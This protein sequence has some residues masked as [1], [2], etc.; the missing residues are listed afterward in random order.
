ML[1]GLS[2][3]SV[4]FSHVVGFS[5]AGGLCTLVHSFCAALGWK[6]EKV[7]GPL[8][9]PIRFIGGTRHLTRRFTSRLRWRRWWVDCGTCSSLSCSV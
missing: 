4:F 6:G 2:V 3:F 5:G 1:V 7:G 8:A 9:P